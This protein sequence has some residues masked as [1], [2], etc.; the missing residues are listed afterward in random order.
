MARA[1]DADVRISPV[2]RAY[3]EV[4]VRPEAANMSVLYAIILQ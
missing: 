3:A 2:R 1:V 4:R